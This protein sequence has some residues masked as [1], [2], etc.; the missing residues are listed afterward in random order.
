MTLLRESA[1]GGRRGIR[2]PDPLGVNEMRY[3]YAIRPFPLRDADYTRA[4]IASQG[5]P[6]IFF[7]RPSS[8]T[9]PAGKQAMETGIIKAIRL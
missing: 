5:L 2:T 8:I 4:H 7:K 1:L 9:A 6:P 3:R